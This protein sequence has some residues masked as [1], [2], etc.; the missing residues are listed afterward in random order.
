MLRSSKHKNLQ[1]QTNEDFFRKY[2]TIYRITCYADN[3]PQSFKM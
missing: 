2:Y 1:N 3:K